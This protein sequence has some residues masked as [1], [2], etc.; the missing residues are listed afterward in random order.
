MPWLPPPFDPA[1]D[2]GYFPVELL[3]FP[4]EPRLLPI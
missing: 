4:G 3:K 1:A 2:P